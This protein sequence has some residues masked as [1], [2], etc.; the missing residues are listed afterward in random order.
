[1]AKYIDMMNI[2]WYFSARS[3]Q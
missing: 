3:R 1:M 2:F